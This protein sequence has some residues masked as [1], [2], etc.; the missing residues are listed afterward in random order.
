MKKQ[1]SF[2][3]ASLQAPMAEGLAAIEL[4]VDGAWLAE[5]LLD[6]L[7]ELHKWNRAYNLTA[8]RDAEQMLPRHIFDSLVA[9]PWVKGD[10]IADAGTGAGLPG[11]PL[12]LCHPRRHFTLLDS[13]GKKTRF[14]Q[15]AV[16]QLSLDNVSVVQARVEKFSPEQP[17]DTVFSRAFS[18]L[19]EFAASCGG[20]LAPEGR[21]VALK[22]KYP[23]EE[24][25][26]LQASHP[27]WLLQQSERL[28]V[29]GLEGERHIVVLGRGGTP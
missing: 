16:A 26:A 18:S 3:R 22:G 27:E 19:Q 13:N 4:P 9:S 28:Q 24:L 17:F 25:E 20:M 5:K 11:I 1:P 2:A 7:A 6:Y 15:H 10:V 29:P 14:V 12:A 8:V 21:L 23:Q